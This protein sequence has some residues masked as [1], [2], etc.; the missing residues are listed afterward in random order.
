LLRATS[1]TT[2]QSLTGYR[3]FTAAVNGLLL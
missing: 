1:P 3:Y 2:L